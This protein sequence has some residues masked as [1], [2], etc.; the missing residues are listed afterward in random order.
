MNQNA[1]AP[2][3]K[4]GLRVL[5]IAL[6]VLAF[7]L[8][9]C[10]RSLPSARSLDTSAAMFVSKQAPLA[11]SLLATPE[12]IVRD[13]PK[14][15]KNKLT[16]KT[17]PRILEAKTGLNYA[18]DIQPWF[19]GNATFAL[20]SPDLD[21]DRDNA[22]Q[23]GYLLVLPTTDAQLSQELLQ[24]YWE[25]EA[26][27]GSEL[28]VE[29]YGGVQLVY[30]RDVE[31]L[32][33]AVVGS[34]FVLI[35]NSP[36]VLRDAINTVQAPGLSLAGTA[37][38]K[39]VRERLSEEDAAIISID[40]PKLAERLGIDANYP[41][42]K[43]LGVEILT[44][45]TGILAKTAWFTV[46]S[47]QLTPQEP[48]FTEGVPL[49]NYLPASSYLAV[50]GS[51]LG[52]L[53]QRLEAETTGYDRVSQLPNQPLLS[54]GK[55]LGLD[56][57]GEILNQMTGEYAIALLPSEDKDN[58]DWVV[59]VDRNEDEPGLI[60]RLDAIASEQGYST[61]SFALQEKILGAWTKL[62]TPSENGASQLLEAKVRGVHGAIDGYEVIASSIAAMDKILNGTAENSL[63][64]DPLFQE[65]IAPLG[66]END[67]YVFLN[68]R[69]AREPLKRQI[70]LLRLVELAAKPLV[71][72]LQTLT[73]ASYGNSSGERQ[74]DVFFNYGDR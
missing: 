68:W 62:G 36:K 72:P 55:T 31:G 29:P 37:E 16:A 49:L 11:I 71:D 15:G 28:V 53:S 33:T 74:A 5:A 12:Q 14:I 26:I 7:C 48:K 20:T 73:I 40:L 3:G 59:M 18:E 4:P 46:D 30:A 24:V 52:E 61:G 44:P 23:P 51:N 58:F 9:G 35:S 63:A 8:T 19:A 34:K 50:S 45:P 17:L 21:R 56:V 41:V 70:P 2:W 42:Y 13:L 25:R 32:S 64:N 66:L 47:E 65:S 43:E 6:C 54:L 67:G 22:K 60:A 10:S 38:Y 39:Q 1:I 27:A 57:Q 69:S